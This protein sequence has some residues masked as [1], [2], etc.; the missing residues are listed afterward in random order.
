MMGMR[1]K[2]L[3]VYMTLSVYLL[4]GG[5]GGS[6]R[7]C[8]GADGHMDIE[9]G[10]TRCCPEDNSTAPADQKYPCGT[11]LHIPLLTDHI[12]SKNVEVAAFDLLRCPQQSV[13]SSSITVFDTVLAEPPH[14]AR[15]LL[16]CRASSTT[17]LQSIVLLC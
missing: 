6:S 13:I 3:Q 15:D 4:S 2:Q 5:V 9:S 8:I 17:H 16:E 11:C 7:L 10:N 14:R 12:Q 1:R